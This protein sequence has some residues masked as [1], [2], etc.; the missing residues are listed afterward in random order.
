MIRRPPRSTLTDTLFP[1]TTLFRHERAAARRWR[2]RC[3]TPLRSPGPRARS[4]RRSRDEHLAGLGEDH[5]KLLEVEQLG[6][7]GRHLGL[8]LVGGEQGA[9][10]VVGLV[11]P[12]GH[13]SEERRGGKEWVRTCRSR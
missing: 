13:R 10:V 8:V 3:P 6:L 9:E 2:R 1:D 4:G 11:P 7:V 12:K 5:D